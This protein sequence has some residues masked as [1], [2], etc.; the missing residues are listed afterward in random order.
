MRIP[1]E[2]DLTGN[3]CVFAAGSE[4]SGEFK[5]QAK[6]LGELIGEHEFGLVYGGIESGLMRDVASGARSRGANVIGVVPVIG[7]DPYLKK[8]EVIEVEDEGSEGSKMIYTSSLIERKQRM[9]GLS[10]AVVALPGGIGTLDEIATSLERMRIGNP[11]GAL[12]RFVILNVSGYYD[13]LRSQLEL[14]RG[15][16]LVSDRIEKHIFFEDDAEAAMQR[17]A[18]SLKLPKR[19]ER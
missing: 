2:S 9:L 7:D 16:K 15:H 4:A 8:G 13:G 10:D 12:S 5:G 11:K 19:S 1:G 17:I 18:D 3:I 6:R 14:M